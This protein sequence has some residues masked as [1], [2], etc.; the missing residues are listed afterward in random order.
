VTTD[1][2]LPASEDDRASALVAI[3]TVIGERY[4]VNRYIARGG[5]G[6]VYAATDS[7]LGTQVALKFVHPSLAADPALREA[8][9]SEVRLA[10]SV[11][12]P[13]VARTFTLEQDGERLFVVMELLEGAT[14]AQR[15]LRGAL[16]AEEAFRITGAVLDALAAA[17]ERGVVHRDVKPGNVVLC[18]DGRIALMDFGIAQRQIDRTT[19][20]AGTPGYMAPEVIRGE[21]AAF[22]SD[23]YAVGVMLFEMLAGRR[24][25]EA[26]ST[27]EL[28][29]KHVDEPVPPRIA[30]V[31]RVSA[32]VAETMEKL[33]A[34]QPSA[35]PT[36]ARAARA[37]LVQ[38]RP[39]TRYAKNGGY[40]L[41]YQPVGSSGLDV[42]HL[43][44]WASHIEQQWD[45]R[46][47]ALW[48]NRLAGSCRLILTDRRGLGMSDPAPALPTLDERVDDL[49]AV[50]DAAGVK[51]PVLFGISEGGPV[52]IQFAATYPERTRGLIL[53]NTFSR[54][55]RAPDVPWGIPEDRGAAI[56]DRWVDDWGSGT[57]TSSLAPTMKHD[58][59][60]VAAM[61][62]LERASATPGQ[63]R[64]MFGEVLRMD[65]RH[66][67]PKVRA[68]TL[69]VHRTGDRLMPVEGARYMAQHLANAKLVEVPG[70]DHLFFVGNTDV[71][72]TEI[73]AFLSTL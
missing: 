24:L 69:I 68:P 32:V 40:H 37:G 70:D 50:L 62:K 46:E 63:M 12:H 13:C 26:A 58:P 39:K 27:A 43:P 17:H 29:D 34:K 14:L 4:R 54:H 23:L 33:L 49:I 15:M 73:E 36:S 3:G 64:A 10:Q 48:L 20:A 21:P 22:A 28:L 35:R 6:E 65:V 11:T 19:A 7:L 71:I 41:A 47:I 60:F 61:G 16:G 30:E 38:A 8:L 67:L 5:M 18:D 2:T 42:V 57:T 55:S 59:E 56:I 72:V 44:G 53:C 1:D 45:H 31:C 66:L 52:A 25:Y 51:A 9:R